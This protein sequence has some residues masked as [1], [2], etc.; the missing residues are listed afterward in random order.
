M[1]LAGDFPPVTHQ[2]WLEAVERVLK[3]KDIDVLRSRTL[4]DIT[5]EPLYTADDRSDP[6]AQ[7]PSVGASRR[8][9]SVAGLTGGWDVR[10]QHGTADPTAANE[11]ILTDLARG[12]T[13]IE[14][15]TVGLDAAGLDTALTGVLLDLA[16]VSLRSSTSGLAEAQLLVDLASERGV[17]PSDL[18]LDLGCDPI[19]RMARHGSVEVPVADAIDT[20]AAFGARLDAAA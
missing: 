20:I 15:R 5:I 2:Q 11:A 18:R 16:P 6:V 7:A 4:D 9:G 13:S 3:G 19:G 1:Q 12:V 10:Q 8:A 14:L 17:A